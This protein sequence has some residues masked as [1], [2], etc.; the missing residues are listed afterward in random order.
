MP[1]LEDHHRGSTEMGHAVKADKLLVKPTWWTGPGW[2]E[3]RQLRNEGTPQGPIPIGVMPSHQHEPGS[4]P[5][6][7]APTTLS[8]PILLKPPLAYGAAFSGAEVVNLTGADR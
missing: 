7:G 3:G 5:L 8:V 2:C 6:Q 4:E 1:R